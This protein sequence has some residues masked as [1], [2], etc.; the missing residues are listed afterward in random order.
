MRQCDDC[1][2]GCRSTRRCLANSPVSFVGSPGHAASLGG[3]GGADLMV[4]VYYCSGEGC[5]AGGARRSGQN[6]Y[7]GIDIKAWIPL[8]VGARQK[9]PIN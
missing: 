3:P 2:K 6:T 8:G 4:Q 7:V 1:F 9:Q 5:G